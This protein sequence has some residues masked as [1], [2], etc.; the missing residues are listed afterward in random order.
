MLE[1]DKAD[2]SI[3]FKNISDYGSNYAKHNFE[4]NDVYVVTDPNR[5]KSATNNKGTFSKTDNDINKKVASREVLA[6]TN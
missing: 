5:I 3:L 1:L 2:N 6:H 4:P